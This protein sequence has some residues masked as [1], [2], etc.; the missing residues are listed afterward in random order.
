MRLV[1]FTDLHVHP[2]PFGAGTDPTTGRQSRLQDCLNVLDQTAEL[3]TEL[4]ASFR[5]FCGDMF[6]VRGRL[7]PSVINPVIEHFREEKSFKDILLVGNHDME[8]RVEG[9]HALRSLEGRQVLVLEGHGFEVTH[10]GGRGGLGIG[11]VAYEPNI[12]E[13]KRKVEEVAAKR[14]VSGWKGQ[15]VFLLHHGVDGAMAHIP[16]M[17]FG[18]GDLPCDDFDLVL[19]GDYHNHKMLV[20]NKAWMIGAPLHHSFGDVGEKRG[21]MDFDLAA[22]TWKFHEND[23]APKFV[24]YDEPKTAFD[25]IPSVD[26]IRGN[27]IRLRSENQSWLDDTKEAVE[28]EGARAVRCELVQ[29][30][31]AVERADVTLTMTFKQM[32]DTWLQDQE[33]GELDK[34]AL[35]AL[36]DEL[37][38]EA[39][40][41]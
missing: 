39:G 27:F 40:V 13:L 12:G 19:C 31:K 38:K 7:A 22:G 30:W 33:V 26:E 35:I 1:A 16:S 20:E 10:K 15:A 36:N 28:A 21:W 4:D 2:H 23:K 11:W 9:E 17:G 29:S 18:P 34:D 5:I 3:A 14:R 8:H 6:H 37:L 24:A 32:F 41:S 25:T